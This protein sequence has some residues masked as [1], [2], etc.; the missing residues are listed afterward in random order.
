MEA[1]V[2]KLHGSHDSDTLNFDR[3]V[4]DEPMIQ[5]SKFVHEP[6]W[7]TGD[8]RGYPVKLLTPLTTPIGG[9]MVIHPQRIVPPSQVPKL[10]PMISPDQPVQQSDLLKPLLTD[11]VNFGLKYAYCRYLKKDGDCNQYKRTKTCKPKKVIIVGAGM[12]GLVAAYELAQVGHKVQVLEMQERVG[13]RVK[14]FGEKDGFGKRL[15]VDG[16]FLSL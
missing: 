3:D 6:D 7:L 12:A 1:E 11:I 13:G 5:K 8:L 14:T 16:E 4:K 9:D 10:P 2:V 15:H